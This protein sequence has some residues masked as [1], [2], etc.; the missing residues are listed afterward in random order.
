MAPSSPGTIDDVTQ[1][2]LLWIRRRASGL[3]KVEYSSEFSRQAVLDRL[4]P[5]LETLNIPFYEIQ[6][7]TYQ[8]P[9]AITDFL[10]QTLDQYNNGLIS[11]TGFTTAFDPKV[12]LE[13]ALRQLNM[14]REQLAHRPLQQIWWMLPIFSQNSL[15][16][17]PDLT[18]WFN[19][20]LRLTE[21]NFPKQSKQLVIGNSAIL[22]P[23][24]T[25]AFS[26]EKGSSNIDDARQRAYGLIE[27]FQIAHK[28]NTSTKQL[29]ET[30]LLPAMDALAA[31]SAHKELQDISSQFSG[32]LNELQESS[33]PELLEA[34]NKLGV[35]YSNQ[36]YF[37]EA[38]FLFKR[39][40]S[41]RKKR[42]EQEHTDVATSLNN[43]ATI[44][45]AQ[46]RYSEAELSHQKALA[47]REK[48]LGSEHPDVANSLNNLATI[49]RAQGRYSEAELA[50][51]KALALRRKALGD[52]NL[53]VATGFN[54]LASL[55][56]VQG[57]YGEAEL[58]YQK[59][60]VLQ[61]KLLGDEH[62][63]LLQTLNNLAVLYSSQDRYSE[64]EVLH[65]KTLVLRQ[66][67]LG[68]GHPDMAKVSTILR[69]FIIFKAA[70]MRQNPYFKKP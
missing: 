43:L 48:L 16:G 53:D 59:A 13:D 46:G 70:L 40:V 2:L 7:P 44:Y 23:E 45:R 26:S 58:L 57:R 20:R 11:I 34:L 49:Y 32:L 41:I 60:L 21:V 4:Q 17:M 29:L 42:F 30:Y 18:S 52:E 64:A 65:Q 55:Y 51:Q 31:V 22:L 5:E 56:Y 37:S 67:I 68:D 24:G 19:P 66:K 8:T 6:L 3:A 69:R 9:G 36:G 14:H 12:P 54:N 1:R 63:D 25:L 50:F 38:E 61:Q 28:A 15:L 47:I 39:V 27:Q 33:S 10:N 35:L 62:P